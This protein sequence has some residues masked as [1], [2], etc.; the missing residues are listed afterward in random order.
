MTSWRVE[1]IPKLSKLTAEFMPY[2]GG[3]F[4]LTF[5][6]AGSAR[7]QARTGTMQWRL[8]GIIA[9]WRTKELLIR[10]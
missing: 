1:A 2:S 4:L 8:T 3:C 10:T 9:A 7:L 6:S 5:T